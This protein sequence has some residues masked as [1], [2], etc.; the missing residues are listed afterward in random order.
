MKKNIFDRI[1][2]PETKARL[3]WSK[4]PIYKRVFAFFLDLFFI[5]PIQNILRTIHPLLP[6]F[7]IAL[8]F[9]ISESSKWQGT[10]GKKILGLKVE[11]LDGSRISFTEAILRYVV[12]VFTLALMGIGY[13]PLF[14][15][16]QAF[17]DKIVN[18]DVYA[19]SVKKQG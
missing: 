12:K 8:Y 7:A 6:L 10:V 17:C 5:F 2:T 9:T 15:K 4:A 3:Y 16:K 19:L 14:R 1:L 13:W 11:H 18:S